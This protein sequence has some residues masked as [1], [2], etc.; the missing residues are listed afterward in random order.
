MGWEG[1]TEGGYETA[2]PPRAYK[3]IKRRITKG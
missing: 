3:N 2:S 1:G